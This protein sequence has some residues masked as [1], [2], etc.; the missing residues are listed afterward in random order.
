MTTRTRVMG[1]THD[2]SVRDQLQS[3]VSR[4]I[5]DYS[6]DLAVGSVIRCTARCTD[7]VARAQV[8]PVEMADTVE[9][10]ARTC[11]DARLSTGSWVSLSSAR[12]DLA[13]RSTTGARHIQRDIT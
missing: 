2:G 6:A 13:T 1:R 10:L 11:L 4:L 5:E 9:R 7:A 3:V 12:D 8:P